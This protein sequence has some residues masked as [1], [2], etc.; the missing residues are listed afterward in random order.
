VITFLNW[1]GVRAGSGT[2]K[3]TS[4]LK[5]IALLMFVIAC[6]AL[7]GRHTPTNLGPTTLAAPASSFAWL[8]AIVLSFQLILGAYGGWNSVIYFAEKDENPSRNIPR[9]LHL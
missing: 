4:F 8:V 6:F 1:I 5:A 7:S 2:Q 3:L 9:S